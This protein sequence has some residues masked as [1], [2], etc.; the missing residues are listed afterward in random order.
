MTN[1]ARRPPVAADPLG[2]MRSKFKNLPRAGW[3]PVGL[4][5][6]SSA[7]RRG[8]AGRKSDG[9]HIV[10]HVAVANDGRVTDVR[11]QAYGCPHTL[12][13]AA[14]LAEQL[15]GRLFEN[16]L[17]SAPADRVATLGIP[18][19]KLGRLLLIEDALRAVRLE[20]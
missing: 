19:E 11:F 4:L 5:A 18:V 9:T 17:P 15:P 8:E 7:W 16:L 10:F 13:T 20:L 14:W 2:A 3:P 1:L 6:G 12:V